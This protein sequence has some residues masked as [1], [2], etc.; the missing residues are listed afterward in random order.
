MSFRR[1]N[2]LDV[3]RAGQIL[4][5]VETQKWGGKETLK[6]AEP[7]PHDTPTNSADIFKR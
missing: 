1:F 4:T 3:E 7:R 2:D 5:E 6:I